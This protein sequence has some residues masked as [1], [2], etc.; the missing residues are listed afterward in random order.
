MSPSTVETPAHA[1]P[2][3]SRDFSELEG[4]E[5]FVTAGRTVTES[6]IVAFATLTGDLHPQHVDADW[7]R[8]SAFGQ[9]VAH[10][11]LVL[12]YAV[13]LVPLD[14]ERVVALR[15][16]GDAVL[17]RPVL[18]GHTIRVEGTVEEVRPIDATVGLVA[19]TWRILN[20]D[21]RLVARAAVEVLWRR[22]G[23]PAPTEPP[24]DECLVLPL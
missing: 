19:T 21:G 5:S 20:Q 14:P 22:E 6:D 17:K 23:S 13:G 24:V 9:R 10:G 3:F 18:I 16:I 15:R 2:L 8:R 4:G 7:A 12:S 11:M 1:T